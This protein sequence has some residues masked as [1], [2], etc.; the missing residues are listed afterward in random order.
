MWRSQK[1]TQNPGVVSFTFVSNLFILL[2][3]GNV[4]FWDA[5]GQWEIT[6]LGIGLDLRDWADCT[7]VVSSS[8]SPLT[9][10]GP[11]KSELLRKK[12]HSDTPAAKVLDNNN[13]NNNEL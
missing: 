10:T 8:L 2:V 3:L 1:H 5:N 6:A 11:T 7:P 9:P 13:N 4:W 12:V